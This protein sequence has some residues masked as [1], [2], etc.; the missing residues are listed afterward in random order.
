MGNIARQR[1]AEYADNMGKRF[2]MPE[3]TD[4]WE[5]PT[6]QSDADEPYLSE[7]KDIDNCET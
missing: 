1:R 2:R 6:S 4:Q 5:Q 3:E 7:G